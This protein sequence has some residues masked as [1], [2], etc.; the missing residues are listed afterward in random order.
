LK[1]QIGFL[2]I[3]IGFLKIQI[4]F[5][6]IGIPKFGFLKIH[7]LKDPLKMKVKN[8]D[9]L[10]SRLDFLKSILDLKNTFVWCTYTWIWDRLK[11]Q[12]RTLYQLKK[13]KN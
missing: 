13:C 12:N 11:F 3:Q 8:L 5:S 4:G 9:F 1:I 10:K 6:R 7:I 2:K